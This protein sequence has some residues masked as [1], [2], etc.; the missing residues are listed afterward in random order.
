MRTGGART[1]DSLRAHL[2]TCPVSIED[3][4]ITRFGNHPRIWRWRTALRKV[5]F[6]LSRRAFGLSYSVEQKT[7]TATALPYL[8]RRAVFPVLVALALV[9]G[10]DFLNSAMAEQAQ[11]WGWG[12]LNGSTYDVL[13][14]AAAATTGIFLALY[15]AAVST[16]AASVYVNV[17]QHPGL[18]RQRSHQQCLRERRGVHDGAGCIA[19]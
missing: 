13:F 6:H 4:V 14:E 3:R 17:T 12:T 9:V 8:L 2:D 18:A 7:A 15:F 19:G 1:A 5:R 10:M 16:V 11:D